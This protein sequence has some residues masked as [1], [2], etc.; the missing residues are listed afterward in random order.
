[1]F[2]LHPKLAK[3]CHLVGQSALN[4][5]LLMDDS[6]Y[7]WLILVPKRDGIREFHELGS[8]DQI[9]L[10]DDINRVSFLMQA[11]F[12]PD[13]L[14]IG[15]LGNMVPQLHIHIV[16]RYQGDEAWPGPVWGAGRAVPYESAALEERLETLGQSLG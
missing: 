13:K 7:P 6:R 2:E 1:M 14:N 3:D 8:N 5:M 4:L 11:L 10:L 16:G 9:A 15:A 12:S